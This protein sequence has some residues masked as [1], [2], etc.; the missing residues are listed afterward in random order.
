[1]SGIRALDNGAPPRPQDP[2]PEKRVSRNREEV[3][4]DDGDEG[5]STLGALL[6]PAK[7]RAPAGADAARGAGR[8]GAATV[9]E[10]DNAPDTESSDP[11]MQRQMEYILAAQRGKA[12]ADGKTRRRKVPLTAA[13]PS[14]A[15]RGS[16]KKSKSPSV[17][18]SASGSASASA[19]ASSGSGS[20][21]SDPD[22]DDDDDEGDSEPPE[23]TRLE[24]K[25]RKACEKAKLLARIDQLH[26]SH[27]IPKTREFTYRAS[28]EELTVEVARMEVLAL[29]GVR[30]KQGR[31]AFLYSVMG[32]EKAMNYSDKEEAL[33]FNWYMNGFTKEATRSIADYDDALETAV[34]DLV[35]PGGKMPW[36][37][38]LGFIL[39]PAMA[40]HSM[41]QRH[42]DDP[43][44]TAQVL[45]DNP[46]IA[47]RVV[48]EIA[49][50]ELKRRDALAAAPLASLAASAP[51]AAAAGGS[52]APT[53]TVAGARP[54]VQMQP[55]SGGGSRPTQADTR[56]VPP[57][58]ATREE[59]AQMHLTVEAAEQMAKQR[60][61]LQ[62]QEARMQSLER[63][64]AET[65]ERA[66]ADRARADAAAA[67]SA[68]LHA[69][70]QASH[71]AAQR[72]A[73]IP[74]PAAP[75]GASAGTGVSASVA[76]ALAA[77]RAADN[78]SSSSESG[79]DIFIQ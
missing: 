59:T 37:M 40:Q 21:G 6:N 43:E 75:V 60:A 20:G 11:D 39:V 25:I 17:S 61:Q 78:S 79:L 71:Q 31:A 53:R 33:P 57:P 16:K 67:A 76:A 34:E 55:A 42:R 26:E 51:G 46:E 36:Y 68:A 5:D 19:S 15:P 62:A 2:P 69:S 70:H 8:R 12:A 54:R 44:H 56:P 41:M 52:A 73:Q 32:I 65:Q 14:A 30:V 28:T 29:R 45:R 24:R 64:L 1:M 18:S 49:R 7:V 10:A 63:Q 66:R 38:Q 22:E 72:P 47:N 50:A 58:M 9:V 77:A 13:A 23:E 4:E 74:A 27:H 3:D 35:G 48:E